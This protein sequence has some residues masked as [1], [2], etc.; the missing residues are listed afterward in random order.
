LEL[1]RRKFI[2]IAGAAAGAVLVSLGLQNAT[3]RNIKAE[4]VPGAGHPTDDPDTGDGLGKSQYVKRVDAIDTSKFLAGCS[5]CGVCIQKCPFNAIRSESLAYPSLD[6]VTRRKCPGYENCGICAVVCPTDCLNDA[7]SD[8][9]GET[10]VDKQSWVEGPYE[11]RER[12]P[13]I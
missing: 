12:Q 5:R 13:S 7:F 6:N 1:T 11:E 3:T 8:F 9:D 2:K 10:A 4:N